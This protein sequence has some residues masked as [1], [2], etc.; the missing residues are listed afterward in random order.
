M[1]NKQTNDFF[2]TRRYANEYQNISCHCI[3]NHAPR[4]VRRT[5][6]PF[7]TYGLKVFTLAMASHD[8][9]KRAREKQLT[10]LFPKAETVKNQ[11]T[12]DFTVVSP[13]DKLKRAAEADE[14]WN[15]RNKEMHNTEY[16][17]QLSDIMFQWNWCPFLFL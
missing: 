3:Q 8:A 14:A 9:A 17:E 2:E 5:T 10:E 13:D 15:K 12:L 16:N 1:I 4:S 6:L 11:K 7:H